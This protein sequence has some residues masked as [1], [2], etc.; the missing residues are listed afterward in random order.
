M[1]RVGHSA[2]TEVVRIGGEPVKRLIGRGRRPDDRT[3][4]VLMAGQRG[5][6]QPEGNIEKGE[7][8]SEAPYISVATYIYKDAL[9]SSLDA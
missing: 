5:R 7:R 4:G 9:E 3:E 6:R 2:T 8:H 1:V